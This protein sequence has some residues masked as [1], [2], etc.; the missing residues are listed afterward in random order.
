MGCAGICHP[1]VV[2]YFITHHVLRYTGI[3]HAVVVECLIAHHVLGYTGIC[4]AVVVEC[5]IAHHVLRYRGICHA[6]VV[7]Y[8]IW[9]NLELVNN[10]TLHMWYVMSCL[11]EIADICC[12]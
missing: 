7:E 11:L 8:L 12:Y 9:M 10:T 4:H 3:C 5:L 2:E 1:L 6:V